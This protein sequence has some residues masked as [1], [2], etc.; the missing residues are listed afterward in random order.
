M[1]TKK[2]KKRV[3]AKNPVGSPPFYKTPQKLQAKID[4]YF[5]NGMTL[6]KVV[7]G[8]PNK[9]SIELIPCPT[10][11]GLSLYCGFE[12]RQSFYEYEKKTEFTY[13]IKK[14]RSR[15]EQEYE[16]HLQSG[17]GAGAIFALKNFGWH[18]EI[19][20]KG[21]GLAP[22]FIFQDIKIEGR[23]P[24]ELITDVHNR[25]QSLITTKR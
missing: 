15:I 20:H 23:P 2:K 19:Y 17:L 10:I 4:K 1:P 22:K 18:D 21:E 24:E 14:A 7:V 9:R 8:P 16:E 11:T 12:S 3:E 5:K 13:T 25:I 6:K